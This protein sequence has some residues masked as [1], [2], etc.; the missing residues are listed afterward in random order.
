MGGGLL[1][2]GGSGLFMPGVDF[3]GDLSP[4]LFSVPKPSNVRV[5]MS[6]DISSQMTCCASV[7]VID[8][9]KPEEAG[10]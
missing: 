5:R 3:D 2:R 6:R 4:E 9:A 1:E 8:P 7:S 10:E